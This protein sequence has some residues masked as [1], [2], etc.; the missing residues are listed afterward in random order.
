MSITRT[1]RIL[2][3][4]VSDSVSKKREQ[5]KSVSDTLKA[6]D[7]G[8]GSVSKN[9]NERLVLV[10]ARKRSLMKALWRARDHAEGKVNLT[11]ARIFAGTV[12]DTVTQK[13]M[14]V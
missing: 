2:S 13:S 7:E 12:T 11:C 5:Q 4:S 10:K 3:V 6:P 1:Q 8:S 14:E 9:L